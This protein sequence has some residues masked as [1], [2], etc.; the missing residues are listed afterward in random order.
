MNFK[1]AL[2]IDDEVEIAMLL[3]AMLSGLG[4]EANY[5]SNLDAG[6]R[7]YEE[8]KPQLVFLDLNLPDGSGFSLVPKIKNNNNLTRIILIT[9]QDGSKERAMAQQ[10]GVD[11][12][13]P[14]PL[15]RQYILEALDFLNN[16]RIQ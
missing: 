13:L 2:V 8:T 3:S 4:M 10:L 6:F 5:A 7:L 11:F 12:I 14:K 1:K 16:E 15:N 9:A